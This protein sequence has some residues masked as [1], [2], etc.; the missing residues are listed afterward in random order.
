ME[1]TSKTK[2]FAQEGNRYILTN[3]QDATFD[4]FFEIRATGCIVD[5]DERKISPEL[6][7]MVLTRH[8]PD[9]DIPDRQ[10]K[11]EELKD[12]YQCK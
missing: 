1:I 3:S 8:S 2:T 6:P 5:F 11:P 10:I 9:W 7:I 4:N 12:F